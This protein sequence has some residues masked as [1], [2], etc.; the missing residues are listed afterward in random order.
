MT[1]ITKSTRYVNPFADVLGGP[2]LW[3]SRSDLLATIRSIA[4]SKAYQS[5][6]WHGL[7]ANTRDTLDRYLKAI[8]ALDSAK[9]AHRA[10]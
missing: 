8:G 2:Q 4:A 1:K 9:N 6:G 7:T 3:L 10:A 5:K